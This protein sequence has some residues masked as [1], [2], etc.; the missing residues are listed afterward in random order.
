V[1]TTVSAIIPCRNEKRFI[2]PCLDSVLAGDYPHEL[3]EVLVVDGMSSDGTREIVREYCASFPV[4][5]MLDNPGK[6]TPRAMN[7]GIRAASGEVIIKM[8][9][10][11]VYDRAYVSSCVRYLVESGADNIGGV[12]TP[13][14]TGDTLV[15]RMIAAVLSSRFGVGNSGF[16]T[17]TSAPREA[18]TAAFGCYRR[19]VF[20]RIGM[21]NELLSRGQD[22]ELNLRLKQA[23]GKII[24]HPGIRA[25]YYPPQGLAPFIRHSFRNG[26]WAIL[27]FGL[28]DVV[29]VSLRHLVPLFFV[30][31]LLLC[32]AA[33]AVCCVI[34]LLLIVIPYLIFAL[35]F[36]ALAA[37]KQRD[38]RLFLLLPAFFLVFHS[39][40]GL[41]SLSG[42]I[43]SLGNRRFRSSFFLAKF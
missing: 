31:A 4:V 7:T 11:S 34:P 37:V 25:Q 19:D 24:L 29:P 2:R 23:G 30:S 13:A 39:A 43:H 20:E 33:A 15:T 14:F 6:T 36:S 12:L 16:R 27:P 1:P 18:D 26:L 3:M 17:G 10:H 21:F 8:D 32:A 42:V 28:S 5:R 38:L 22:M 9:A 41:G 40:Y 35:F